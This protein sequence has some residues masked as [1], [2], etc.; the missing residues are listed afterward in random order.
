V[1][2]RY[3][4]LLVLVLLLGAKSWTAGHVAS[5]TADAL[6]AI[7][8]VTVEVPAEFAAHVTGPTALFYFSPTCPH[9]R[10]AMPEIQRLAA[11]SGL[12]WIAVATGSSPPEQ[13]E[14]F[15]KTFGV[16]FPI[17]PDVDH[18]F[19]QAVG[20]RSTPSVYLVAPSTVVAKTSGKRTLTLTAAYAPY[21]RGVGAV[22]LMRLDTAHPF[23][24]FQGYQGATVC[25]SCH[26]EEGLSWALTH[27]ATAYRTLARRDR[28]GDVACVGCHVT[29]MNAGGF[30]P[31]DDG[32]SPFVDVTCEA[33]HGPSGPHDGQSADAT[34]ACAG[35]HD[36]EHSVAFDLE[37]AVPHIDH[38]AA[39]GL[40]D[41]T[42]RT[43]L[44][45]LARGD[46]PRPLLAFP[47]GPTVGSAA[48]RECHKPQSKHWEKSGHARAMDV[49]TDSTA[50]DASCTPCHATPTVMGAGESTGTFRTEEGVGCESCHGA[51][52]EH[53][54][55]PTAQ[56]IVGLGESCPECV[57]EGICTSCHTVKWD[58]SWQLEPR[59]E[60]VEH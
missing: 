9:C 4:L 42:F 3:A 10:A 12:A 19:Q 43:R 54:K 37:R 28:A 53:A 52:A 16:T 24:H 38:Y 47:E 20:A 50:A 48:C 44:A 21:T 51:G 18:A 13:V 32:S 7:E 31:T 6:R 33:C 11:P 35:C 39:N 26:R 49:L 60:A 30:D 15:R 36:P 55:H 2:V 59:L 29:G 56:N 23:A 41:A 57:I 17:V 40:D 45:A 8:P 5:A 14:E 34:T 22:L 1:S 25:V 58:P 46:A 27:H